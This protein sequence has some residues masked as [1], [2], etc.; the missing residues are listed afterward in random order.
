MLFDTGAQLNMIGTRVAE[1]LNL[2]TYHTNNPTK[3]IF[4]DGSQAQVS[5]YIPQMLIRFNA[6][7]PDEKSIPLIFLS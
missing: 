6:V 1:T 2:R 4:P 5:E 3:F 7:T